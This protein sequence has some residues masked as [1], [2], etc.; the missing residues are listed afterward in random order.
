MSLPSIRSPCLGSLWDKIQT[1]ELQNIKYLSEL[2]DT[3]LVF[4]V[5]KYCIP[6]QMMLSG[7]HRTVA[8][9]I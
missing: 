7:F 6:L 3:F 8:A 4:Q 1:W 5:H 9:W 2:H